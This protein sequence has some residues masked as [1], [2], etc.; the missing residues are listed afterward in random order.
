MRLSSSISMRLLNEE[1][2]PRA[3]MAADVAPTW[4]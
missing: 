3:L 1:L 4:M 2:N